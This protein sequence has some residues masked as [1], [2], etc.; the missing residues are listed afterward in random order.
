M[1]N[2]ITNVH[3]EAVTTHDVHHL[4]GNG[5]GHHHHKE[6]FITKYVFSQ[7]HKTIAK[8]FLITGMIWAVI[9]G[10]F[11]VLFRLQLGY[12]DQTFPILET[13]FGRYAKGG[14]IQPEFYYA[15]ITMHGTVLV[16]FVLTGGLSG[17]FANLLIPLQVGARDM[18]SPFLNMLSYWFFFSASI[19]M[20]S[21]LFVQ[22]GPASGGWTV[23]P[24]LS[25]LGQASSGS[26][27]GM[28][29]W[30]T[31]MALFVVS[32]L[33]G[34]LNYIATILNMRTK[35]MSM[36]RMPLTMWAIFFT[37]ILGVL[38]FPVLLSGLILLL[39]DRNLGTSF[40]LSDIYVAGQILPN[41]GGSAIL[42]QHLF[43]FLGHPEVYII[44][45]PAMGLVS[46]V[47]S[48]N[49]RKPIFGYM[50][51]V[52]SLFAI[53]ILAF[54][55][56]AHHMFVSG[57]NPFL[58]SFFVLLTLLIAIPSAIKVFNWITTIWRG[59]VRFTPGMLFAIGFVSLFISGGLTGI[60][61]GNSTIDIH[62]H[63]TVFIVAHFH[64]VM[65]VS[66]F[67]GMFAGVYHWFPKMFGRFLNSTLGYIHFWV[68][69]I[70]AYM[71]FWPMHYEGL[72][73]VPRR[74][75]NRS[76]WTSFN[77]FGDLNR[78]ITIVSIVVFAVQLM[79]VFNFFYSIFKGRKVRSVN[80]WGATTLEWS[81]PIR[82]GHGNWPGE[83]PEVHRWAYDY[84]KDG[85]DFIPQTE[86]VNPDETKH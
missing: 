83:I 13:F 55:V 38:S 8:Q 33:L 67:F 10:L 25:A 68:T 44:I 7:D 76:I 31:A 51:M 74:Y 85:R 86:P 22:T 50:A 24:P 37:A 21:S 73:G 27:I 66:A 6:S 3:G 35:G 65:G 1:S 77:Q 46:E 60:W 80:P 69:I 71:I 59:N 11:S 70:G 19:V 2:E 15:L 34:G 9:G 54:L 43:W 32:S 4:D 72:A 47:M 16:F 20:F 53:A 84:S 49:S 23:Y 63:D 17:T 30:I 26:K 12:P 61:L 62:V 78:M 18:A 52:G 79:F 48:I 82:P 45:L 42:Y 41:E 39:F 57:L 81:T 14:Q 29:L 36:T 28:D 58:G 56:W 75:L 5:N 40:Y 64:I